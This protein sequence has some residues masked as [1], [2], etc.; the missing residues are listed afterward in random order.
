[1][2]DNE[3]VSF[4]PMEK[5]R[6]VFYNIMMVYCL[7]FIIKSLTGNYLLSTSYIFLLLLLTPMF[8]I[9][10]GNYSMDSFNTGIGTLFGILSITLSHIFSMI[11]FGKLENNVDGD[12]SGIKDDTIKNDLVSPIHPEPLKSIKVEDKDIHFY[13]IP[14]GDINNSLTKE[15]KNTLCNLEYYKA[16]F[17]DYIIPYFVIIILTIIHILDIST[18]LVFFRKYIIIRSITSSSILIIVPLIMVISKK[19]NIAFNWFIIFVYYITINVFIFFYDYI[20]D[21]VD[22]IESKLMRIYG[23]FMVHL[24]IMTIILIPLFKILQNIIVYMI[25]KDKIQSLHQPLEDLLPENIVTINS[26]L[27]HQNT[28]VPA[29]YDKNKKQKNENIFDENYEL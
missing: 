24:I 27:D 15:N 19:N 13:E 20:I 14:L 6:L 8:L 12:D 10:Y 9:L 2:C 28:I 11:I 26:W 3:T 22:N 25:G 1:M 17:I 29:V 5:E 4:L 23:L 7:G 21:T 18:P 16:L